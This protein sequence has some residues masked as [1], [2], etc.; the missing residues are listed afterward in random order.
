MAR[1]YDQTTWWRKTARRSGAAMA[2]A[3]VLASLALGGSFGSVSFLKLPVSYVVFAL[4]LP[5]A[6]VVM[7]FFTANLQRIDD[8][9]TGR[10]DGDH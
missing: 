6:I 4:V 3:A 10:P 8:I 7:I 1:E 9:R 5:I 2:I